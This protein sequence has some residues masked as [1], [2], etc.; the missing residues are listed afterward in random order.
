MPV[1]ENRNRDEDDIGDGNDAGF[2]RRELAGEDSAHDED[3]DDQR[4][5]GFLGRRA[6]LSECRAL[7]L[8][9]DRSE[10]IAVDHQPDADEHPGTTPPRNSP[11][12][13]TLP[14]AP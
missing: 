11:P 3:R 13:E 12:I 10:E 6:D 14:V 4:H 8:E 9:A 7:V 2:G 1:I 5:G